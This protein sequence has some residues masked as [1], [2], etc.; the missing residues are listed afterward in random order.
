MHGAWSPGVA[1]CALTLQTIPGALLVGI[2]A[3]AHC[4][5]A[6]LTLVMLCHRRW[7]LVHKSPIC[8]GAPLYLQEAGCRWPCSPET[9]MSTTVAGGPSAGGLTGVGGARAD[10]FCKCISS[11]KGHAPRVPVMGSARWAV[12]MCQ[13]SRMRRPV[14]MWWAVYICD[15]LQTVQPYESS[16]SAF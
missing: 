10:L 14:L 7:R 15:A 9:I 6:I 5:M 3:S 2:T 11:T 1:V 13:K 12:R 4:I 16:R 8:Q